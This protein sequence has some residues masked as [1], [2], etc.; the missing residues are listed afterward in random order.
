[1]HR[2]C[3]LLRVPHL[4][5]INSCHARVSVASSLNSGLGLRSP[6]PWHRG[7]QG[8]HH[9]LLAAMRKSGVAGCTRRAMGSA[10]SSSVSLWL[11]A[12]RSDCSILSVHFLV[13]CAWVAPEALSPCYLSRRAGG[14]RRAQTFIPRG[15][16]WY[17]LLSRAC[18]WLQGG[19]ARS[20]RDECRI[21]VMVGNAAEPQAGFPQGPA[22]GP[23]RPHGGVA[24]CMASRR[25]QVK[26][27]QL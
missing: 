9:A 3:L 12:P 1:M 8:S 4:A 20:G 13:A 27:G 7:R 14:Q 5:S 26:R 16:L 17:Y 2:A 15:R 23:R 19:E 10:A 11:P 18:G 24:V 25:C 22:L 21:Q 6:T